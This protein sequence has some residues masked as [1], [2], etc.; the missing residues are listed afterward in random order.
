MPNSSYDHSKSTLLC[1]SN[2]P[3]EILYL[4][5]LLF[6]QFEKMFDANFKNSDEILKEDFDEF[7]ENN[8]KFTEDVKFIKSLL[9]VFFSKDQFLTIVIE[10]NYVDRA[11]RDCY[12]THFSGKHFEYSRYCKRVLIFRGNSVDAFKKS[13]QRA[14]ENQFIGSIVIKPIKQGAIGRTLLSPKFSVSDGRLS[15]DFVKLTK[16]RINFNG[17]ELSIQAFPFSMQDKE[18]LSCAEVTI[19]N[20][21]DYYG[22]RYP[23]YKYVL[24]SDIYSI[25]KESGYERTLPTLGM[26]YTMISKILFDFGFFPKLYVGKNGYNDEQMRRILAYYI[27]SAIPVAVGIHNNDGGYNHSIVCIG[28]GKSDVKLML[29]DLY[30]TFETDG[31]EIENLYIADTANSHIDYIVMDDNIL[32]YSYY[33]F[34]EDKGKNNTFDRNPTYTFGKVISKDLVD[35][36]SK[37]LC[38]AVPLYKRMYMDAENA[39]Y[40]C[41]EILKYRATSFKKSV[42]DCKEDLGIDKIGTESSP[43]VMRLFLTSSRNF[44]HVRKKYLSKDHILNSLY[45]YIC[46]PKFV[47]VCELFDVAGYCK[48]KKKVLGEIVLDA[49]SA[50]SANPMDSVISIFYPSLC[51]ARGLNG[52]I[53]K[54]FVKEVLKNKNE[55][56]INKDI[57]E[58]PLILKDDVDKHLFS[59]IDMFDGNLSN[60][61]TL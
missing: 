34:K 14:L 54:H 50:L 40:I 21:M 15:T 58:I 61:D 22:N 53:P 16:Y 46:F 36:S 3:E 39:R 10:N 45:S 7:F 44:L 59:P 12:Y 11:Y 55:A 8:Y 52:D 1:I 60:L 13:D 31:E 26:S 43:I 23:E 27:E 18:T 37:I 28:H 38:L 25:L 24:P 51:C 5:Y 48:D 30:R 49:T 41:I 42:E 47:W 9:E 6:P 17:L 56:I 2:N 4:L 33:R 32:P 57:V 35:T 19:L 20:I 29:K